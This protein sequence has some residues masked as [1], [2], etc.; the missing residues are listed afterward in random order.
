MYCEKNFDTTLVPDLVLEYIDGGDLLDF[1]LTQNG[2][3]EPMGQHITRQMCSAL[4]VRPN[5]YRFLFLP[6]TPHACSMSTR[7]ASPTVISS[8]RYTVSTEFAPPTQPF[9][10]YSIPQ[11]V[12]LTK[13][14]PPIVKVADF[15][16]AKAVDS[17]TMLRVRSVARA[18][19]CK[20]RFLIST[21]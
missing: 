11:N 4:S 9:D 18:L 6:L 20:V 13:D 3:E 10:T 15:G 21:E 5:I 19:L 14:N 8:P 17:F 16:L 12:L 1:I 7:R 2:L